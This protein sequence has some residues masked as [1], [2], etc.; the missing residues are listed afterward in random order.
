MVRC[1]LGGPALSCVKFRPFEDVVGIGHASG[2]SSIVVPGVGEAQIDSYEANPYADKKQRQETVV[3][4]LLDKLRP[5]MIMLD[6][7]AIASVARD[8]KDVM[9]DRRAIA[10]E[11]DRKPKDKKR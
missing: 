8:K 9:A 6:P 4:S 10:E 7:N 3:R 5:E 11:A 1:R 2:F